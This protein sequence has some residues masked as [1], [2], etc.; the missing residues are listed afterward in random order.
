MLRFCSGL[1]K[2]TVAIIKQKEEKYDELERL[3][4]RRRSIWNFHEKNP[5]RIVS[6]AHYKRA[7]Q[8][9]RNGDG[10]FAFARQRR[11][12][13]RNSRYRG[14]PRSN[15]RHDGSTALSAGC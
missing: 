9:H 1:S 11:F 10:A 3:E 4:G 13:T 12:Q 8:G 15:R 14:D 7:K 5:R 2:Q 6:A